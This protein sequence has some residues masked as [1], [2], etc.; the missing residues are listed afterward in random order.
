LNSFRQIALD[1]L[2]TAIH[3]GAIDVSHHHHTTGGRRHLGDAMA[4]RSGAEHTNAMDCAIRRRDV[5]FVRD[6]IQRISSAQPNR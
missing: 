6:L 2:K 1:S 3:R 4:H 5:G